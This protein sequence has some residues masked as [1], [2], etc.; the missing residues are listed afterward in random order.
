VA[1]KYGQF[2]NAWF[3]GLNPSLSKSILLNLDRISKIYSKVLIK[4]NESVVPGRNREFTGSN[5]YGA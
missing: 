3:T 4:A 1:I 5:A 2:D